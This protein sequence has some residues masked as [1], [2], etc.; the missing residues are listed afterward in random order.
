MFYFI[1]SKIFTLKRNLPN[2][3]VIMSSQIEIDKNLV[4]YI[5]SKNYRPNSIIDNLVKETKSLG[6]VS[7]MQI[8]P[9]QG[10]FLE[11][12]VKILMCKRCLEVGRFTGLSTL[13]IALGLP[14]GGKIFTIDNSEEFLPLAKKYWKQAKV[15]NKI[16]SILG[17]GVEVMQ[18]Y[19]DRKYS[20]DFIFIDADKNNYPNYYELS[21]SLIAPNGVII[22]DNMLWGG[23]VADSA[24]TDTQTKTIRDLNDKILQDK[25]IEFCLMPIS[26]GI[27][28]IKKK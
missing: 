21:L 12:I 6:G 26:D 8:A 16:D 13:S 18:S 22:F 1:R 4:N 2:F 17:N 28:F 9:E 15:D 14:L 27:S 7:Q 5:Q 23:K 11:I 3:I 25:R 19:I 10:K 20:F 24:I